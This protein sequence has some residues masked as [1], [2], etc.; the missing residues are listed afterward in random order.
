MPTRGALSIADQL[1]ERIGHDSPTSHVEEFFEIEP[2][3]LTTFV[4]DRAYLGNPPLSEE[5]Y[6]VVRHLE[7]IFLPTTYPAM[8]ESFGAE[9]EPVR[10]IN[11]AW[12]EWGKGSG[13]DHVCRVANARVVN[14]LSCLKS[15]Q[16]YFGM[17]EQDWIQ[18][19]NVAASA[20]QA[21]RAFFKPLRDLMKRPCFA[22]IA[23]PVEYSIRF[24]KQIEAVSG[25]SMAETMEGLNLIFGIAD[26]I[27]AFKT[28]EEVERYVV[29]SGGREPSKTAESILRLMRTSG[30]TR[31]P[32]CF[33]LAAISY[34]RFKGDAIQTLR[35]RGEA[36]N[37]LKGEKSKVLVSGPF[38]TWEVNPRV[39]SR[40]HFEDDYEDDAVTARAMYECLPEASANRFFSN[41]YALNAAFGTRREVE[42]VTVSY[43]WGRDKRIESLAPRS[44][45]VQEGWQATFSFAPDF[46]P[47]PGALYALHGDMAISGDR[48]GIAMAHVK[49][50]VPSD[51]SRSEE[52]DDLP[53]V[54]LD[55]VTSFAADLGAQPFRREVQIRWYRQLISELIERG[56]TVVSATF[57]RFQSADTMQIL[58]LWGIESKRVSVDANDAA[59]TAVRDVMYEFRFDGYFHERVLREFEALTRLPNGKIDHP[60]KGSKDESD[61]VAGAVLG[62][63]N[64]GGSEED[65]G[66][67]TDHFDVGDAGL[68]STPLARDGM[69]GGEA[70][71]PFAG[72]GWGMSPQEVQ[73]NG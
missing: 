51:A 44:V 22:D 29:N 3:P 73:W 60:P 38:A 69:G 4:Q 54:K 2:V 49:N 9:W 50:W 70:P 23:D 59:Y 65:D 31:F 68:F 32:Q 27:S 12:I 55:F 26:E 20:T 21:N 63:L 1:R 58:E 25:H 46:Q 37:T 14:L 16:S 13:K 39:K 48:A 42:P 61:A 7:Q 33:K 47:V 8:V 53:V 30:R 52:F 35:I 57:D 28:K 18:T 36:D 45:D 67:K 5:Q 43:T 56:F 19:L 62:A 66:D 71:D 24:A 15:P 72:L 11:F 6:R 64:A 34:P 41:D 10:F 17:P 40:E